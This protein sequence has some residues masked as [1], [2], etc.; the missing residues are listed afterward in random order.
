MYA[1]IDSNQ[2]VRWI[3]LRADYPNTSFPAFIQEADLP[4]GV[5]SVEMNNPDAAPG[6]FE[7]AEQDP[8]PILENGKWRLA[9]TIRPMTQ[10]EVDAATNS[11]AAQVRLERNRLL[12][13]TD[14]TQVADAPVDQQAWAGYRQALR[15]ITAQTGFPFDIEWP[16]APN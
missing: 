12:T 2:F 8:E 13:E 16:V 9:Y 11:K 10:Q 5:V 3:N 6:R 1:Q 15:D 4:D 14:W 7:V